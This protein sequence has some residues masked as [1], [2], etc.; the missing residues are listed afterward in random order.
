MLSDMSVQGTTALA[1][2]T[3]GSEFADPEFG[4]P[5]K[6]FVKTSMGLT[7]SNVSEYTDQAMWN[8]DDTLWR[9][10]GSGI[11]SG[12]KIVAAINPGATPLHTSDYTTGFSALHYGSGVR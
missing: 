1:L 4:L 11:A 8:S 2:Q 5:M 9:L 3:H 10:T 12:F 6:R 7:N